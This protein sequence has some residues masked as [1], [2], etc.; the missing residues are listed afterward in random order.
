[1]KSKSIPALLLTGAL[2]LSMTACSGGAAKTIESPD[3][4]TDAK[5]SVQTATTA[6]ENIQDMLDA[7]LY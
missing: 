3:D 7:G 2:A 4:F 6:H 5:I 1:M